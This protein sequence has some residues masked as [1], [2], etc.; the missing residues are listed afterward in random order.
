[1]GTSRSS[2]NNY[3]KNSSAFIL[4]FFKMA[5][6]GKLGK[7]KQELANL[8]QGIEDAEI[9]ENAAKERIVE[10]TQRVERTETEI[11]NIERRIKLVRLEINKTTSRCDEMMAKIERVE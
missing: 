11:S 2:Y 7:M 9:R 5:E 6:Q 1:M 10:E 3:T 8:K 4:H